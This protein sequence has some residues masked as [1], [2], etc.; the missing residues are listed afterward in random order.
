M[1]IDLTTNFVS[2]EPEER[3][4]LTIFPKGDYPFSILEINAFT[5]SKNGNDMLPVKMEFVSGEDRATVYENLVFTEKAIFKIN[6][7][8]ASINVPK[9]TRIN[10]RDPEFIKYLSSKRGRAKLDIEE[11]T[12]RDGS[13]KQK[14][15]IV[16]FLYD[17]TS[18]R[19][20]PPAHRPAAPPTPPMDD[21]DIPF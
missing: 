6:Q 2:G 16:A 13:T 18:K 8:L 20:D 14:N 19:E 12:G 21:D 1:S 10:F 9:G 5:Q 3:A 17:G 7:F 4:P 11:F 15:V